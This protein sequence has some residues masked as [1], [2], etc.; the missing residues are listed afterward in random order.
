MDAILDNDKLEILMEPYLPEESQ[1]SDFF[2]DFI[3]ESKGDL[4]ATTRNKK[5]KTR[6]VL[7]K[8]S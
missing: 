6:R 3:L 1:H 7:M 8:K 2:I 4:P 5:M